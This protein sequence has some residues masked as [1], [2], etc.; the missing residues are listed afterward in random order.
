MTICGRFARARSVPRHSERHKLHPQSSGERTASEGGPYKGIPNGRLIV[1]Y[2]SIAANREVA[3]D[4]RNSEKK[5]CS[6][7]HRNRTGPMNQN[8]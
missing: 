7:P 8:A 4:K 2:L 6:R 5:D 3:K 1:G